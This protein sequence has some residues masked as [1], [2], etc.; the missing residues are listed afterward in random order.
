MT[1]VQERGQLLAQAFVRLR[2][3]AQQHGALE[4]LV[5]NLLRQIAP[6]IERRHAEDVDE[7]VFAAGCQRAVRENGCIFRDGCAWFA[8]GGVSDLK[9]RPGARAEAERAAAAR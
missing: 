5:L 6:Q 7:P 3:V 4:D 1:I 2:A 9:P 8:H